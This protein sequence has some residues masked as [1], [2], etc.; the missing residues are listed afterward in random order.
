MKHVTRDNSV[1]GGLA[2]SFL[3][4]M[5]ADSTFY[6]YH[7]AN[8]HFVVPKENVPIL[9]IAVGTGIAPFRGFL[10]ER[11]SSG[12]LRNTYLYFGC[13]NESCVLFR[14][15]LNQFLKENVLQEMHLVFSQ[16]SRQYVQH[17][18]SE[19]KYVVWNLIHEQQAKVYVCGSALGMS[20]DI[21]QTFVN[22]IEDCLPATSKCLILYLLTFFTA[23]DAEKYLKEMEV[24]LLYLEDVWNK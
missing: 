23:S 3:V 20:K 21:Y 11:K 7:H 17:K 12:H 5:S 18:L 6:A 14:E 16:T 2:S 9:L 1:F 24:N 4:S 13:K 10:Q 8:T 15:E 22:I 19:R